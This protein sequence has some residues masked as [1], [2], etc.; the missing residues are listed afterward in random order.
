MSMQSG[1]DNLTAATLQNLKNLLDANSVVGDPISV[2]NDTVI[3]P[4]SQ[5]R[6]GY[7]TGGSDFGA[8]KEKFG[9]GS[10]AGVTITPVAMLVVGPFETKILQLNPLNTMVEN[11]VET[12]PQVVDKIG[13][14]VGTVR[15]E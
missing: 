12:V 15:G 2:S 6:L 7:A 9:G 11:I 3:I 13:Q 5:L 8:S 14:I 4:I 10:G 1:I